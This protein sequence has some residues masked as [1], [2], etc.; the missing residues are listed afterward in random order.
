MPT[1]DPV[2]QPLMRC[3][4]PMLSLPLAPRHCENKDS[5]ASS[6]APLQATFQSVFGSAVV[7]QLSIDNQM[8]SKSINAYTCNKLT[9]DP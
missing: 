6:S 3:H 1:S 9:Q 8:I 7:G 5:R 2:G 4:K